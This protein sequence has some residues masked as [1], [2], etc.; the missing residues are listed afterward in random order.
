MIGSATILVSNLIKRFLIPVHR[1][2]R[3]VAAIE[4]YFTIFK[5]FI[6]EAYSVTPLVTNLDNLK[7]HIPVAGFSVMQN[8]FHWV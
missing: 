4:E 2:F 3:E 7:E 8:I 5:K 6:K 1:L